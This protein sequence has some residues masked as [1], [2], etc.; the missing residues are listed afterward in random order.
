MAT[1]SRDLLPES[2][3]NDLCAEHVDHAERLAARTAQR[4]AA[5]ASRSGDPVMSTIEDLLAR[6]DSVEEV[7]PFN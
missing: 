5:G 7:T 1:E 2:D 6:V 4:R 3:G